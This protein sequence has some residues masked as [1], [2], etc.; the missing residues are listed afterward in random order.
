MSHS[1]KR[2]LPPWFTLKSNEKLVWNP[3]SLFCQ[4]VAAVLNGSTVDGYSDLEQVQH[5]NFPIHRKSEPI[6]IIY[7]GH[8]TI[9]GCF[10]GEVLSNSL[11][12]HT[13]KLGHYKFWNT[14]C[15]RSRTSIVAVLPHH[16]E[17]T[18]LNEINER[19]R[20]RR[21]LETKQF[22]CRRKLFE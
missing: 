19:K 3:A 6:K 1:N 13:E 7:R 17:T 20:T 9:L 22:S 10:N 5:L 4:A 14:N 11:H 18:I 15:R 16:P 8:C 21:I 12:D 2:M